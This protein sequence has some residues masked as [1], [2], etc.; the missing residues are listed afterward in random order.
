MIRPTCKNE[1]I[2][3]KPSQRRIQFQVS[4]GIQID[5]AGRK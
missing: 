2:S 4:V 5:L 1:F 3:Y